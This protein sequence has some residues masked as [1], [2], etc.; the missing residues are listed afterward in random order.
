[1][2][3]KIMAPVF[4]LAKCAAAAVFIAASIICAA[5]C[6]GQ[7]NSEKQIKRLTIGFTGGDDPTER[8]N[9][10]K[11]MAGYF[12]KETG[13]EKVEYYISS[14][15]AAV[16]EA[17]RSNKVDIAHLGELSYLLAVERAG[18]EAIAAIGM[19]DGNSFT[20]SIIITGANSG[21]KSMEDVAKRSKEINLAFGDPASTSGHLYP[22]HFFNS[23]GLQPEQSFK[24]VT[25]AT[26]Y[27]AAILSTVSGKT[28]LACTF[29]MAT[30][31][32]VS[33]GRMSEDDFTIIWESAPYKVAPVSVR[34]NLPAELKK[35][36]QDAYTNLHIKEPELWA[37][38]KKS[39][40]QMYPEDIREKLIYLPAADSMYT[41]IRQIIDETKDFNFLNR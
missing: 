8:M 20:S 4:N 27:A 12:A 26:S 17:M 11:L 18:A 31:R 19:Q 7:A 10:M 33:K 22:R 15:Y 1:M 3:K 24:S 38:Y 29:K 9:N 2:A 37:N 36:I 6:G 16:I 34:S 14:D 28:D 40:M 41:R 25:F 39:A 21:I 5:G 35:K 32:L 13:V 30:Q 23:I